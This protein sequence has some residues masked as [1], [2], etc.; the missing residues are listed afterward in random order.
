VSRSLYYCSREQSS[1]LA[2]S[3]LFVGGAVVV[4]FGALCRAGADSAGGLSALGTLVIEDLT[5]LAISAV[6]LLYNS[7]AAV[8][9]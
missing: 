9:Q 4:Y 6:D 1:W 8:Q 3:Q 7:T 5:Q 2:S